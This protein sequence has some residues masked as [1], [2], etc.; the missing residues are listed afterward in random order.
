[1]VTSL[2]LYSEWKKQTEIFEKLEKAIHYADAKIRVET[3]A[4][5]I[6]GPYGL[7][8]RLMPT[9]TTGVQGDRRTYAFVLMLETQPNPDYEIIGELSRKLTNEI[10]EIN[11]I[12]LTTAASD[13]LDNTYLIDEYF[14]DENSQLETP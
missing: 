10:S 14:A 2:V 7:K 13:D 8:S 12:V 11:R 6:L 9:M 5:K 1:M 3:R 4:N